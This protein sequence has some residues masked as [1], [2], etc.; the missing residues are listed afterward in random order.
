MAQC[1]IAVVGSI[2]VD[3]TVLAER[4]PLKG[5]TVYGGDVLYSPGGKGANQAVACARLGAQVEMFGCVGNDENGKRMFHNLEEN[6]VGTSHIKVLEGENTG[7]A[8]ITVGEQD[9][10]IVIVAGANKKV[11]LNYVDSIKEELCSFDM[12]VL[13]QEIPLEAMHEVVRFC[14]GRQIPVILNPAPAAKVPMEI[15]DK[16]TYLT[17][18][19]HEAALIFKEQCEK[20]GNIIGS[21]NMHSETKQTKEASEILA[22]FGEKIEEKGKNGT[23]MPSAGESKGTEEESFLDKLLVKY[24]E[25]LIITQGS[26]GVSV[27]LKDGSILRVPAQKAR[28]VDTTGAGDTLNGAFAVRMA[29][30]DSLKE[31]LTFANTAAGLSIEKMGAQGGM[32]TE[33]EVLARMYVEYAEE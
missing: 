28:V 17:P 8:L 25:K 10:T 32:P 7:L 24:P 2:N 21:E 18:N 12:V 22:V 27:G 30:G 6:G 23:S 29:C 16:V 33:E 15:V 19:E 1:R 14:Y 13:Q 3:M 31:A 11:D 26:R 5:E 4:I 9:N 20:D